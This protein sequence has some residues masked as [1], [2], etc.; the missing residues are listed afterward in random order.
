M[1][2]GL[3]QA[4]GAVVRATPLGAE[5]DL[6]VELGQLAARCA[7]GDSVALSG[8]CCTVTHLRGSVAEFRLSAE[9]LRRT[10]LGDA[11]PPRR[12]N[13][14]LALRAGDPLGGHL[15]QGHVD[16]V[17]ELVN[18]P[19]ARRGGDLV[20]RLP[21]GLERYCVDKGSIALDG[22]SLTIAN[23]AG[24]RAT[25]AVI[26]HTAQQTTLGEGRPGQPLHV[27]VDV[28][29]KYVERMLEPRLS[30]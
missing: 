5:A 15:V 1:F 12:L 18:V 19:D 14:E 8:V 26:P 25:I 7:I 23:L 17:G 28:L 30:N 22:V 2:T 29:A 21:V 6:A 9:T 4:T 27:E 3:I 10:W 24:D 16:A 13:L 11:R 20:V